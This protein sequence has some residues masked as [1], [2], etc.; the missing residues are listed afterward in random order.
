MNN[1]LPKDL[2]GW[3]GTHPIFEQLI[4][5]TQPSSIIE[6]GTW[7]GQ[8]ALHMVSL[9]KNKNIKCK[10]Y[11]VD[12][13]LGGSADIDEDINVNPNWL[14]KKDG[15]PQIYH[16]FMSNVLWEEA[17]EYIIPCPNTSDN[18]FPVFEK[19]KIKADLIYVD[20]SH[21]FDNVYN[22]I[23]NYSNLLNDKGI[24]FGD[25]FTFARGVRKAVQKYCYENNK[26]YEVTEDRYWRIL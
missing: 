19:Q 3:G 21:L 9:L 24:I 8:S 18:Y 6:I 23:K 4:D 17:T 16:Q 13:W 26:Q 11:C 2:Q 22:D 20:G 10:I 1:I 5:K 12:T 14:M 25:D 15:Y 7:K